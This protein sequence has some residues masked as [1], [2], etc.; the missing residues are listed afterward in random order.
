MSLL[1]KLEYK[2][3]F[4]DIEKG[5]ANYIIDHK[6]EVANMRLVEL[7]EATFTSTATISRFCKKLGEKNYNSFKINFASSVLTSFKLML[8]TIDLLKRM[9]V[10]K[11][12]QIS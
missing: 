9:I 6:E 7:A 4:S 2:K 5:I 12:S 10:F 11:K 8:I 3:G 1:S